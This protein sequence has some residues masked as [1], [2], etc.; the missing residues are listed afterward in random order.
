MSVPVLEIQ[1][2]PA[3]DRSL[4][5]SIRRGMYGKCPHCGEGKLFR[6]FITPVDACAACGEDYTH[7]R[8]D[9]LPAYIVVLI[10]GHITVGAFLGA[11]M[12]WSLSA[13]THLAIWTPVTVLA[14]LALLQPVKGGVIGLQWALKMHGFS[15]H[16]DGPADVLPLEGGR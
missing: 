14:S 9:D 13:M 11:E 12:M 3:N 5:R 10:V 4:G 1:S 7:Q 16:A 6:K 15:G 8:A 2:A